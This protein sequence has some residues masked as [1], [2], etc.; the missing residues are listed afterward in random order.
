MP[1]SRKKKK[2]TKQQKK[3]LLAPGMAREIVAILLL[4]I[5]VLLIIA[6]FGGGGFL[7]ESLLRGLRLGV[8]Y[9]AYTV[10]LILVYMAIRIF[11]KDQEELTPMTYFGIFLFV[12]SFTALL[13][14]AGNDG[15]QLAKDGGGGGYLGYLISSGLLALLNTFA[16]SVILVATIFISAVLMTNTKPSEILQR[17]QEYRENR[18]E[19][20]DFSE[21]ASANKKGKTKMVV[22]AKVPLMSARKEREKFKANEE[23]EEESALVTVSNSNWK[24]PPLDILEKKQGK[25][26]AGNVEENAEII[27]QTLSS[28]NIEVDMEEANV[29]PTVTQYTLKPP[30]NVKLSKIRELENNLAL[31]LAAQSIRIEAPI[32]GKRAV[33]IEVPNKTNA[34]V[35]LKELLSS[36]EWKK[37]K[38]PLTFVLGQGVSGQTMTADLGSMP[39]VLIAGATG[40]GKS[41]MINSFLLSLMYRNAPTD[42]RL[43]LVDPKRVELSLYA[44]LPHLLSP[45]ITEPEKCISALKWAVKEMERRYEVFAEHGKRNIEEYNNVNPEEHMPYIVIV[46]DE[47]ADMMML[48]AN[49]VESLIVRI[50]QKARATGIHLVLATQRPSVNVITGLIKANVPARIAFTTVSQV[51]SRTILDQVGAEKLLG[52]GDMLFSAPQ[53]IKPVRI[54]GVYVDEKEVRSVTDFI[55]EEEAPDYNDEVLKQAVKLSSGKISLDGEEGEDDLFNEAAEVVI[56]SGKGSASLLQRRLKVGYA[57]AARILDELEE[58]GIVGPPEGS[59]PRDVLVTSLSEIQDDEPYDDEG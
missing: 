29:G 53:F 33:G 7:A 39:H 58:H 38:S 40:S 41:V 37:D 13:H 5:A 44:D 21:V 42:M 56:H 8:G 16:S 17:Y 54:Q 45:V 36:N 10:P 43:I 1:K 52:K 9:V 18:S 3:P 48:S 46:I 35:R 28:F 51:D 20:D 34:I 30:S 22:N 25:A 32:P 4:P 49:D 12:V 57:R 59:K 50:A 6:F 19:E 23:K 24:F 14:L 47:L 2:T 26:D 55:R 27:K 15:L 11:F 31:S